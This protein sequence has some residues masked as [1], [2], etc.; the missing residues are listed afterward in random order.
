MKAQKEADKKALE[1][2]K[3]KIDEQ[4]KKDLALVKTETEARAEHMAQDAMSRRQ[5][6]LERQMQKKIDE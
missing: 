3:K 1:E 5:Q 6:E 2:A 4:F